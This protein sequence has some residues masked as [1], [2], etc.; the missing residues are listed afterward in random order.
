MALENNFAS[1]SKEF[2]LGNVQGVIVSNTVPKETNGVEK[3]YVIWAQPYEKGYLLQT[4]DPELGAWMPLKQKLSNDET[5]IWIFGNTNDNNVEKVTG[6][7]SITAAINDLKEA[8]GS[9]KIPTEE[10]TDENKWV[11]LYDTQ[12]EKSY[13]VPLTTVGKVKSV[14]GKSGDVILKTSDLENNSDF[15]T[16]ISVNLLQAI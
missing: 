5:K 3:T 15:T 8:K 4:F 12:E 7:V 16:T 13:Y 10:S 14:N 6:Y 11:V 2:N 1:N 9:V